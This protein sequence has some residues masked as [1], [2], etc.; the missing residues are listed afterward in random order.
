MPSLF[1]ILVCTAALL[2]GVLI[3]KTW[4]KNRKDGKKK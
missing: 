3:G 1:N 2:F 4:K